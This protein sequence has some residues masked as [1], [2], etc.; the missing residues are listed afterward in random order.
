MTWSISGV[1][2]GWFASPPTRCLARLHLM[3][4][5]AGGRHHVL[6]SSS[7]VRRAAKYLAVAAS[8]RC[9]NG[10]CRRHAR[11]LRHHLLHGLQHARGPS[12][13]KLASQ[14]VRV[15]VALALALA[16]F[17]RHLPRWREPLVSRPLAAPTSRCRRHLCLP[18]GGS[19]GSAPGP[20]FASETTTRLPFSLL[21]F[22]AGTNTGVV[23]K[24][25]AKHS[26]PSIC[27]PLEYVGRH[28]LPIYVLHNRSFLACSSSSMVLA[29]SISLSGEITRRGSM[30]PPKAIGRHAGSPEA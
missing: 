6:Y 18:T 7:N 22:L 15:N 12:Y 11:E 23:I 27:Q 5:L 3:D 29:S 25:K 16:L 28:A 19:A 10:G 14:G 20:H 17:L 26:E 8:V 21:L 13:L 24:A 4:V 2:L 9:H 1:G 30:S